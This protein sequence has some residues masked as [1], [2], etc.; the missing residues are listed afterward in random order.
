MSRAGIRLLG[1]GAIL[2]AAT[3]V[4]LGATRPNPFKEGR[5][6][7]AEFERV[8][9]LGRIDRNV[10]I[11]GGNAGEI[12]DV[13][14]RGDSVYVALEIDP[15]VVVHEDARANLRPHTLFEGSA[16][17]DLHP[18]SPNAPVLEDGQ[19]IPS[20][21]TSTYVSLDEAVRVLNEK[22]RKTLK[23]LIRSTGKTLRGEGIAG[24]RRTLGNAPGLMRELGPTARALQ[25]PQRNELAGALSGFADTVD[26]LASQEASLVPLAQRANRTVRAL[27][28]D[29]GQPLDDALA[30]LPG[31]LERLDSA[32]GPV[33]RLL[34]RVGELGRELQPAA[35]ELTPLLR[36]AR[37][38]MERMT[39]TIEATTPMIAGLRNVL[40]RATEA[41]PAL[42]RAVDA[43]R[44][45][46]R[47]MVDSLLPAMNSPSWFGL[48]VYAQ[49]AQAFTAAGSAA[50]SFHTPEQSAN[51][52]H[53]IRVG[54]YLDPEGTV[55]GLVPPSCSTIAQISQELAGQ[56]E[57]LGLCHPG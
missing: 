27:R 47:I 55:G 50:R 52:G 31:A 37:P 38:L 11:G 25:G 7:V 12:G 34:E 18:G 57:S 2:F 45:G 16:F 40:G 56:L 49:L 43:L 30:A 48:P 28:V 26:A 23:A 4:V 35:R 20:E 41:A 14:R 5:T 29:A 1:I 54:A 24:L 8:Q 36:S 32:S 42:K 44:P 9:G 19:A 21:Q 53:I 3:L 46:S 10:R 22:N 6:I 15:D 51:A 17:V 13:R 33:T 39:P